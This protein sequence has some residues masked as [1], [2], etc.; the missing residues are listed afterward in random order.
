[1]Y[2]NT[3]TLP[4]SDEI[5]AQAI[6]PTAPLFSIG[7]TSGHVHT[8]RL[9]DDGAAESHSAPFTPSVSSHING[10]G[11]SAKNEAN[12]TSAGPGRNHNHI[13]TAW[14]TRRHKGSCRALAFSHDGELLYSAGTDGLVKIARADTGVVEGKIAVP[15]EEGGKRYVRRSALTSL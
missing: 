11:A 10:G 2:E 5:F 6:H 15:A 14:K 3:C 4:F 9:P 1:M 13:Q 8:L 12:G 7:L